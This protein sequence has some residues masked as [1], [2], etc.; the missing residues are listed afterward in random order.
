VI[1]EI[2]EL[3]ARTGRFA[4]Q[5]V[6]NV[7]AVEMNLKGL[8]AEIHSFKQLLLHVRIARRGEQRGQHV[9]VGEDVVEHGAGL[10]HSGPADRAGHAEA[11]LPLVPFS[12]RK[13]DAPPSGQENFSAPLSVEYMMMVLSSR[14]SSLSL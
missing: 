9:F 13:G 3:L 5:R 8:V 7:V 14:P 2:K 10:N 11:T 12:L 6:G 1:V 4:S